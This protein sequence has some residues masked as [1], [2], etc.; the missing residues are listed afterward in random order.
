MPSPADRLA[1]DPD[2]CDCQPHMSRWWTML[3]A[4]ADNLGAILRPLPRSSDLHVADLRY[5]GYDSNAV[6]MAAAMLNFPDR[7]RA[8][9]ITL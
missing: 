6:W 5:V 4:A 3:Q 8:P 2:I 9:R 1:K 7:G